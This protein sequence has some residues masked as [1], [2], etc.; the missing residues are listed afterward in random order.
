MRLN[1]D[2]EFKVAPKWY[3]S[4]SDGLNRARAGGLR[5]SADSDTGY[6]IRVDGQTVPIGGASAVAPLWA[7][8]IALLNQGR[9]TKPVR[10]SRRSC[11]RSRPRRMRCATSRSAT[12]RMKC[13][14]GYAAAAGWERCHRPRQSGRCQAARVPVGNR[15]H[16][17]ELPWRLARH[18]TLAGLA[19][20]RSL[21]APLSDSREPLSS[22][23]RADSTFCVVGLVP[24][25]TTNQHLACTAPTLG[26]DTC[27]QEVLAQR[28][29]PISS[30][31]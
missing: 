4:S 17:T 14:S 3:L 19:P 10:S 5:W 8:L 18:C 29:H 13:E 16:G 15:P 28:G 12:T 11:T 24:I 21:A 20:D 27:K 22:D 23:S 1:D 26:P 2:T 7:G 25:R 9:P 31:Q 30:N 6:V